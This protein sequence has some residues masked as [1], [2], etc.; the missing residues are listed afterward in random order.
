MANAPEA[1]IRELFLTHALVKALVKAMQLAKVN[2]I[3]LDLDG[4]QDANLKVEVVGGVAVFTVVD[5]AAIQKAKADGEPVITMD[6]ENM[7]PWAPEGD[8]A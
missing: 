4:D 1:Y 2:T 8:D 6:G 3:A 7:M 5:D